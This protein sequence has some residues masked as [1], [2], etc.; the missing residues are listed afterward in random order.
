MEFP[1]Y[2]GVPDSIDGVSFEEIYELFANSSYGKI[3]QQKVRYGHYKPEELTNDE[4]VKILGADVN[5][6]EHLK[7]TLGITNDF[8]YRAR[9]PHPEWQ[10]GEIKFSSE[11]E[12]LLCLT[13]IIHDWGEA[14]TG[15]IGWHRKTSDIDAER[16]F[17]ALNK[18]IEELCRPKFAGPLLE[19]IYKATDIAFLKGDSPLDQAFNAIEYV[20]YGNNALRAWHERLNHSGDLSELLSGLAKKLIVE[21]FPICQS[22]AEIYPGNHYFILQNEKALKEIQEADINWRDV[23]I[24]ANN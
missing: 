24:L 3:L 6:L 17:A 7:E 8:I 12:E 16:E 15:D 22:Y 5:N 14:A 9:Y 10:L 11:E 13:A 4:W 20:G 19:K 2:D 18:I 23:P 21:N 1:K